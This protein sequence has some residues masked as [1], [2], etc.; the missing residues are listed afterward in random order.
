MSSNSG[1]DFTI[2][3]II[4]SISK[5]KTDKLSGTSLDEVPTTELYIINTRRLSLD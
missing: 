4:Y 2:I 1:K 3:H 5:R